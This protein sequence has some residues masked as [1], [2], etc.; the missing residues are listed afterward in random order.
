MKILSLLL[1]L[2]I[3]I[4]CFGTV[5]GADDV[6]IDLSQLTK[7]VYSINELEGKYKVQGRTTVINNL[8]MLDYSASGMEF[9]AYCEGDVI[10]TFSA[11]SLSSGNEG[12]CYFTVI[13]D[14]VKQARD[15]CR[16]TATGE[17][18]F[19]IAKDL[20]IG[21]HTF[22]IYRQTEIERATVGI[23][24]ID[25]RGSFT[26]A[27][28]NNDMYIEFIG[29]SISTAYGNLTQNGSGV[30]YSAPKYQDATQGYAYLTARALNAD[31]SIIAQQGRGAKYGYTTENLQDIYPKLRYNKDKTTNYDFARQPDYVVIALGT[32]DINTYS[33]RFSATLD[34]VKTGFKEILAL[35][36]AKNPDAK[37]VWAYNMMTNRANS[38]ITAVIEEAGGAEKGYYSVSLTQNTA[39]GNG[40][41]YYTAHQTMATELSKFI[42]SLEPVT[43]V[44]GNVDGDKNGAVD[45]E[46]VVVLSQYVAKWQ[47]INYV[48]EALDPDASGECNLA[49]VVLLAQY[50]AKWNVSISNTPYVPAYPSLA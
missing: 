25:I 19:V 17:T 7:K 9:N 32:N 27:A 45:L 2:I 3:A 36:R 48:T 28:K 26:A 14:G 49:D 16:I 29:D 30:T 4:F 41:P 39:G 43:F 5:V 10:V 37:I 6:D 18:K 33:S 35:V 12:G 31:W 15:F 8:L 1:S 50:V 38:I 24:E 46:D 23:K 44:P 11:A 20:K 34:D 40:H 13:V 22:E 47:G 21:N 42:K